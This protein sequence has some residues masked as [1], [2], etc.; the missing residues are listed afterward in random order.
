M[1]IP[2]V[3]LFKVNNGNIAQDVKLVNDVV[4]RPL[5]SNSNMF[6]KL[7]PFVTLNK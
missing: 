6:Y 5:L 2:L 7:L 4:L 3:F 1:K